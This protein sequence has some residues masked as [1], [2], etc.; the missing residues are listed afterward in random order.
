MFGFKI[1]QAKSMFFDRKAVTRRLSKGKRK[2]FSRIGGLTRKIARNS[3]KPASKAIGKQIERKRQEIA[4]LHRR[5]PRRAQLQ[6]EIRQLQK[7]ASSQPGNPPKSV[8]GHL[9]RNIFYGLDQNSESVVIGP[10]L[11]SNSSGAQTTLEFGGQTKIGPNRVN[12][13]ARPYMGPAKAKVEP[14][15]AGFFRDCMK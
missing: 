10:V 13:E 4:L 7:Q 1:D 9:K 8:L 15:V 3:I 6:R 11:K 14:Q 12:I 2:G 5:S